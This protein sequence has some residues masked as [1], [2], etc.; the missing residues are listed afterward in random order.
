MMQN[1]G[2]E[3]ARQ[4]RIAADRD[5]AQAGLVSDVFVLCGTGLTEDEIL[6]R[7]HEVFVDYRAHAAR[8]AETDR[9]LAQYGQM[10]A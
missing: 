1:S 5:R 8:Q 2:Y 3:Q 10:A 6:D 7:V 9:I 4:E